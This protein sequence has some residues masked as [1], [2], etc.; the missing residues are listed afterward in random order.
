MNPTE[1]LSYRLKIENSD[2]WLLNDT[3]TQIT[4]LGD[5]PPE[6]LPCVIDALELNKSILPENLCSILMST[7]S[8]KLCQ[9][10][11]SKDL[12]SN[13]ELVKLLKSGFPARSIENKLCDVLYKCFKDDCDPMRSAIVDAM[14]VNGQIESLN[15]LK[16]IKYE[17]A[18][19]IPDRRY[20]LQNSSPEDSPEDFLEAIK[21][22]ATIQFLEKVTGAISSIANRIDSSTSN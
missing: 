1:L 13:Y 14:K 3:L 20:D 18:P 9:I 2:T 6:L 10:A 22:N 12:L 19:T 17:L 21:L 7:K 4:T 11:Q 16:V 15:L 5:F 8:A